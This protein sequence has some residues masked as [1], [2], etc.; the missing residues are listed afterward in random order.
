M[1]TEAKTQEWFLRD[2]RT[3]KWIIQCAACGQY[4]R[5]PATP[6]SIPKIN[7]EMMFPPMT[8]DSRGLGEQCAP[9]VKWRPAKG[10]T[11]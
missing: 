5:S 1:R 6:A 8:L 7:F 3:R 4:G 10:N 2:P 11:P 9:R